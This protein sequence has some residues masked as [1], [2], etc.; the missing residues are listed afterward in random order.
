MD[1][2]GGNRYGAWE[3][4]WSMQIQLLSLKRRL[5]SLPS[6]KQDTL[7]RETTSFRCY[8]EKETINISLTVT[9]ILIIIINIIT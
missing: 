4:M 3:W 6:P 5:D 9:I 1:A 2:E 7:Y 8:E